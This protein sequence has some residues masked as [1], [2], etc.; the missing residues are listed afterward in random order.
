MLDAEQDDEGQ[1][2]PLLVG[3]PGETAMPSDRPASL[4]TVVNN[5]LAGHHGT[6]RITLTLMLSSLCPDPHVVFK[7]SVIFSSELMWS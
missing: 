1:F 2:A 3:I 4:M 7:F 6:P 5:A